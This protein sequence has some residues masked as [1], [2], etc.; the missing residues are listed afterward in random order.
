MHSRF[1]VT[2]HGADSNVPLAQTDGAHG[3]QT[4]SCEPPHATT[5]KSMPA[6]HVEHAEQDPVNAAAQN[7]DINVPDGQPAARPVQTRSLVAVHGADSK[8]PGPQLEQGA[9]LR[10]VVFVHCLVSYS[11]QVHFAHDA[12]V[13]DVVPEQC[14][15][16]YVSFLQVQSTH[17]MPRL[18]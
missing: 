17:A 12:Q 11:S 15:V 14:R 7:A 6:V 4:R 13:R 3:A 5:S 16:K 18:M 9:H 2:E 8:V 1:D 10:F